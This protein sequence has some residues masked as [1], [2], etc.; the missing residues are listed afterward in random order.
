L[1]IYFAIAIFFALLADLFA[2][3][4]TIIKCYKHPETESWVAYGLGFIGFTMSMLTVEV[5][6][7]ENYAFIVYLSIVNGLMAAFAYRKPTKELLHT[8]A[9]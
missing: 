3:I 4:P 7:F 9:V 2:A 1:C 6:T 5:W 8:E